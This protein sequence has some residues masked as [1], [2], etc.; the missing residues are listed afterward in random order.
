MLQDQQQSWPEGPASPQLRDGEVHVWRAC[1][2]QHGPRLRQLWELLSPDER[3]RAERFHFQR[4]H[5]HFVA[6]RGGLRMILSRYTGAPP[7]SLHFSYDDYGKPSLSR[8]SSG[9][10]VYFN[11]SHS[12]G[13]A[14]YAIAN[15][16]EVGVDI[17]QVREDFA[18][19]EVAE[20]F[21]SP[22]E[23]EALCA[24]PSEERAVAFFDCWTRKEAYIKARGEGLSHPLHL[25]TVSLA[26][27]RPAALLR[28]DD[29]P[30]EAARW[31]LVE[32]FPGDGFRAALAVKCEM[33]SVYCWRWP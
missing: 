5:D 28:T 20:R 6:A 13:V 19:L 8:E 32:L 10:H 11:V 3:Q 31:S 23:V 21:F 24:F 4:D 9:R 16:R 15:V 27:G 25:F 30:Q 29:D 2:N 7:P 22:H 14:L 1:L 12:G 33:P 18:G 17:E 26:P